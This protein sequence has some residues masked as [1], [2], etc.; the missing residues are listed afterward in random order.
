M[1]S[2]YAQDS[3]V[4]ASLAQGTINL[5]NQVKQLIVT[6]ARE[7]V[8]QK[9]KWKSQWILFYRLGR[10]TNVQVIL[11]VIW[12]Q[13]YVMVSLELWNNDFARKGFF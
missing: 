2:S 13:M 6:E 9:R 5:L 10:T 7:K 1:K 4:Q 12:L 8:G 3:T 11:L